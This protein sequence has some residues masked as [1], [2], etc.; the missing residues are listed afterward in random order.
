MTITIIKKTDQVKTVFTDQLFSDALTDQATISVF[1]HDKNALI[2][3]R[4]ML[5]NPLKG[6]HEAQ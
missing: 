5:E 6:K 4:N 3:S 2:Y 1:I